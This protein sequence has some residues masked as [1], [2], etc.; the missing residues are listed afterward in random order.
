MTILDII[1]K[2]LW[3]IVKKWKLCYDDYR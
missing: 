1:S 3:T 2:L